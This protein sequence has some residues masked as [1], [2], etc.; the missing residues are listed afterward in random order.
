MQKRKLGNTNIQLSSLGFGAAPIGDLFENLDERS[1]YD[2]LENAYN[3]N[4]NLFDTSPFYG[5]GLS[6]H[7]TG[8]FLKTIDEESYFLST[9]VGRYL[10]P[11][12][13]QNIDRGAW[14][15]GLN[16]KLNLDYS[17]DGAM[18]S[19]EQSLLRLAVSKI[20]IC[21]IHDVDKF[22]FGNEVDYYFKLAMNGA[23]KAIQKLKEEKVIKAIGVGLNDADICA[24]FANEG[25]FDCMVLAGRYSL[26]E[27][28]SALNDF[29]PIVNKNNI[30]IILAG[31][32]NSGILAKGIGDN[33]TYNYDKIPNHI[34]EKYIIVSEVC[35]RYNVPVPAAALQFSYANKL[36]SS[37]ILGMDRVEQIKQNI[38]FFNHSIPNDLWNELIEKKIIDERCPTP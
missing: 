31:V 11:E 16:F 15:G 20:D 10:T 32:F 19:F 37:M 22:T 29:F 12:K 24:K 26:L 28:E 5:N 34:R 9:K 27:H 36:I 2:I 7:R 33:V 35:D 8:N 13:N 6:E 21:L 4:F 38:S 23:Y 3:Y 18:R 14:A 25:D 17:Y 1:C 30:G